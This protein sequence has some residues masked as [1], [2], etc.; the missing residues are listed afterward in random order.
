[1]SLCDRYRRNRAPR[2][3]E[4]AA[5][6]TVMALVHIAHKKIYT[7]TTPRYKERDAAVA[8]RSLIEGE[9][10]RPLTTAQRERE[11]A[12]ERESSHGQHSDRRSDW[13]RRETPSGQHK[14]S[15][16][17]DCVAQAHSE[18]VVARAG[19]RGLSAVMVAYLDVRG[20]GGEDEG[21]W[22]GGR[23]LWL[24]R[25]SGAA[26]RRLRHRAEEGERHTFS[27]PLR[28]RKSPRSCY[29]EGLHFCANVSLA[30]SLQAGKGMPLAL[31]RSVPEPS[32]R[33]SAAPLQPQRA[34]TTP[35]SF[36]FSPSPAHVEVRHHHHTQ[37]PAA[38]SRHHPL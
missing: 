32:V 14:S 33:C 9:Y 30:A 26:D 36:I 10:P 35:A 1:V 8:C 23:S 29:Y 37:A 15:T 21:G 11:R 17:A 34:P 5:A 2:H 22:C 12:R 4:A 7:A 6:F 38:S 24:E 3:R 18:R 20:G 13:T 28:K 31:L 19:G 16:H 27:G 25:S